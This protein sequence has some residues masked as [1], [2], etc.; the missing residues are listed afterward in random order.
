MRFV[1]VGFPLHMGSGWDSSTELR[2]ISHTVSYS[3]VKS[4]YEVEAAIL[5]ALER[6]SADPSF[7]IETHTVSGNWEENVHE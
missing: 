6:T 3:S 5:N 7:D 2:K 1:R 4:C